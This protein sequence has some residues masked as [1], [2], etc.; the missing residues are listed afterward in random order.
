MHVRL[1]SF[2]FFINNSTFIGELLR[3][4]EM[5]WILNVKPKKLA[6]LILVRKITTRE[7]DR[8]QIRVPWISQEFSFSF[9]LVC[10]ALQLL[11]QTISFFRKYVKFETIEEKIYSNLFNTIL[12]FQKFL[13]YSFFMSSF[14]YFYLLR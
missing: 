1:N 2:M 13:V 12:F 3:R 14:L 9:S 8:S 5:F 6:F 4:K 7:T 10:S 11:Q